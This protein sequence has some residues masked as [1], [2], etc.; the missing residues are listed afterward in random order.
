MTFARRLAAL[1][2]LAGGLAASA[3][4]L[5]AQELQRPADWKTRFDRTAPD[6]ALYFVTMAPG[7]HI[8]SGPS[9]I[10]Y[11]PARVARG[12]YRVRAEIVLFPGDRREGFGVFVGGENLEAANQ[13][14]LYFLIR[15]DG[16]FLIKHRAGSDTHVL[17]PWTEHSAIV[18]HP[19]G[20]ERVE[21]VLE[22]VAGAEQVAFLINGEEVASLPRGEMNVDGIVGLRVNHGLDLHVTDLSVESEG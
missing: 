2:C 16:R 4:V 12:E 20:E 7:W 6:S 18:K 5:S 1:A 19:G 15:K 10:L 3:P 9:A 22:I 13:S 11:D 8:T 17:T 21:N 14:Y